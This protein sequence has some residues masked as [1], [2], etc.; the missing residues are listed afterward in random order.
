MFSRF[1]PRFLCVWRLEPLSEGRERLLRPNCHIATVNSIR[2]THATR[3]YH[4]EK[5]H[6]N[7]AGKNDIKIVSINGC[8][9]FVRLIMGQ[10]RFRIVAFFHHSDY[11]Q[12]CARPYSHCKGLVCL[13]GPASLFALHI[14]SGEKRPTSPD[15]WVRS[16]AP[17]GSDPPGVQFAQ[18]SVVS[19]A[20]RI[21]SSVNGLPIGFARSSSFHGRSPIEESLSLTEG[22]SMANSEVQSIDYSRLAPHVQTTRSCPN[23]QT[24]RCAQMALD[25]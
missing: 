16:Q 14:K 4:R 11:T 19:C 15:E 10:C 20:V 21:L 17:L 24:Q 8:V 12:K 2:S 3:C 23:G 25:A 7:D 13:L 9:D 6:R 5:L 18:C 1:F 22:G